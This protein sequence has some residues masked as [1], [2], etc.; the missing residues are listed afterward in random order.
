VV[1]RARRKARIEKRATAHTLRHS[2]AT[3]LHERG[4]DLRH[5]QTFLGHASSKTTDIYT[6][7]SRRELGKIRSPLDDIAPRPGPRPAPPSAPQPAPETAQEVDT[8]GW[9]D[10]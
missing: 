7:V 10:P 6:H 4:V 1:Q 3:H 9:R 5:I 2:F 8:Q